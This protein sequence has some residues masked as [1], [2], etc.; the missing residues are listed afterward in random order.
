MSTLRSQLARRIGLPLKA[1]AKRES[2]GRIVDDLDKGQWL[3]PEQLRALREK[4]LR[5]LLVEVGR[6]VPFYREQ[7]RRLGADPQGDDPFEILRGLPTINKK[8][9]RELGV[10]LRSESPRR[11]PIV[12]HT[13]GTT[14]ERLEVRV[15]PDAAA[16]RYL[17]GFRGRS[18]WG[19]EPG[20]SEYKI[21]GSGIRTATGAAELAY[22]VVRRMKDWAIGITLVSPFFQK[23]EDVDEAARLLMRKKP[24]LVFGYAN[25]IHLLAAHMVRNGL[26]AGPGWPKA[27]GYTAEMLMDWQREDIAR[28]FGAPLFAE[29]GSCEAGV[30]AFQ[31][32]QGS[33]HTSDDIMILETLPTPGCADG[34]GGVVVTDLM[35][36]T[37]PLIRYQQGDLAR[38]G[39]ETCTCGRGLGRLFD[40]TGRMNE[41]FASRSGGI[42]DFIV[43]D[44]AMKEQ[45]AIRCFKV[46]ERGPGDIVFL[47]ELHAGREWNLADRERFVKQCLSLL[48][49]DVALSV[50][51]ADHLPSEPSGKFRI[52]IAASDA[53]R[54]L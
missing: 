27:V 52:M 2:T 32:P 21:W 37:Y 40:L 19:I 54:Y 12:A 16:Y 1:L 39:S 43:F 4:R 45:D 35:A 29:Y 20:D 44:Q 24:K 22:K 15:D 7:I 11:R 28:A 41:R 38:L 33:M 14:G 49:A 46:V 17:A 3:A 8:M 48:P 5:R 26:R 18:W 13:S 34:L 6:D 53:A 25:S 9:Y 42:I 30:M 31:C 51:V 50:Q 23:R 10:A 47:A 36:T